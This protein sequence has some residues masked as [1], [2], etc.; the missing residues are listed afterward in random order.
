MTDRIKPLAHVDADKKSDEVL[1]QEAGAYLT[2]HQNI[3]LVCELMTKLRE[4]ALPWWTPKHLR[5]TY[6]A[7]DRMRWFRERPDLRQKITTKLT[8]LA[9]KACRK[10]AP[11]FQ[12]ALLDSVIDDGDIE[13]Q[14]FETSF[15]PSDL[16]VYGPVGDF[17]RLFRRRMPWDDDATPHQDVVGWLIG[18]LLSDKSPLDGAPRTPVLTAWEVRTAI[19]GRVW[20]SRV[21][22]DVRVS[23]DDARFQFEQSNPD[24]P[25]HANRDL[26]IAAP[27]LIAASI[28]LKDLI[29][30]LDVAGKAMGFEETS[31]VP[32]RVSSVAPPANESDRGSIPPARV[33]A[34]ASDLRGRVEEIRD[35]STLVGAMEATPT[36][37]EDDGDPPPARSEDEME[38][39]NP[40]V[41]EDASLENLDV[42]SIL[43]PAAQPSRPKK[44]RRRKL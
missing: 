30:V 4:S 1:G 26:A 38:Q 27:A 8:G 29:G 28:P 40:Y 10:K 12:A 41:E 7:T 34:R 23:I 6:C 11:D 18:A 5:N 44:T 35:E 33:D 2:K 42:D 15:E 13:V 9:P 20:H 14:E 19:E 32:E 25:F 3:Q 37:Q 43:P 22:L 24:K 21:P 17:W 36:G 16:V 39:T 31:D